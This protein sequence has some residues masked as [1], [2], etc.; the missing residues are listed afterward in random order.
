MYN[1]HITK[2]F[3]KT[4]SWLAARTLFDKQTICMGIY[5]D[6]QEITPS[7]KRRYDAAFTIPNHI[8]EGTEDIGIQNVEG[9][10]YAFSRIEVDQTNENSFEHAIIEMNRAFDYMYSTWL[11][12]SMYELDD[13]PCLEFYL[14]PKDA[15]EIVIEAYIPVKPL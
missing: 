14:S 6:F 12:G 5:Y 4:A 10:Q 11:P 7:H 13:K 8:T 3:D 9:G 1:T 15:D 2:A